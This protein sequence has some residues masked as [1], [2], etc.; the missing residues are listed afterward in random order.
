M[1]TKRMYSRSGRSPATNDN[2][3][4]TVSP[5][6]SKWE[7][8]YNETTGNIESAKLLKSNVMITS[9]IAGNIRDNIYDLISI[10]G[11]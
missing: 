11:Y 8:R 10:R 2:D 7:I 4:H 5:Y 3:P 6:G 9:S 1:K